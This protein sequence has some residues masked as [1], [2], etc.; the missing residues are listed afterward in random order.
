M[1]RFGVVVVGVFSAFLVAALALPAEA[2]DLQTRS[3]SVEATTTQ[4]NCL[5]G[6]QTKDG[7]VIG[8]DFE[9]AV[10]TEVLSDLDGEGTLLDLPV[11]TPT[12]LPATDPL[13]I[14]FDGKANGGNLAQTFIFTSVA[15]PLN[16]NN[17][18]VSE[19]CE[20]V[21]YPI[22]YQGQEMSGAVSDTLHSI[23]SHEIIHC[24]QH[25]VFSND[26]NE[27]SVPD[28]IIEGTAQYLG[29]LYADYPIPA[30]AD[31][32]RKGWLHD[33][34][35]DLVQRSYDAVG[36]YS[37]VADVNGDLWDKMVPA[38][39]AYETGGAAA[40]IAA[41][42]GDSQEVEMDW[43]PSLLN[44][45]DW[46]DAWTTP[47]LFVPADAQ[48][49]TLSG[50]VTESGESN[51]QS[52][53]P[54][55]AVID[56]ETEVP[57]GTLTISV[58]GGYA[59]VH[60]SGDDQDYLGFTDET[61]CV[62]SHACSTTSCPGSDASVTLPL[63]S[64]PYTLAVTGG[65]LGAKYTITNTPNAPPQ[66][67]ADDS[68]CFPTPP[69]PDNGPGGGGGGGDQG[70]SGGGGGGGG[71]NDSAFSEGD[72]HLQTLNDNSY[73]FQGAGEF[74][75]IRSNSGDMDI[76]AR[77]EPL[78]NHN[79]WAADTAVAM[80]VGKTRIEVDPGT[81]AHILINGHP[82]H[83]TKE[84]V[85]HL[86]DAGELTVTTANTVS[87]Q[88]PD[89]SVA[90]FDVDGRGINVTFTT[91]PAEAAHLK[92]LL[93]ALTHV[94]P[95]GNVKLEGGN[96]AHFTL[97]L[98]THAGFK[99]LYGAFANSWRITQ[100]AS[101]F[102]YARGK[103]TKTYT[104]AAF[105][106]WSV[107]HQSAPLSTREAAVRACLQSGITNGALLT[108]CEFDVATTG[109]TSYAR[110]TYQIQTGVAT[111]ERADIPFAANAIIPAHKVP[112]QA[113]TN[114]T[115]S[116]TLPES[117][118]TSAPANTTQSI[119]F[120]NN[121]PCALIT[122]DQIES[123]LGPPP[124]QSPESSPN[125]N[126]TGGCSYLSTSSQHQGLTYQFVNGPL[127]ANYK[128]NAIGGP[129]VSEP[130]L[131]TGAFCSKNTESGG[132]GVYFNV[133]T[134]NGTT[135]RMVLSVN[136]NKIQNGTNVETPSTNCAEETA[137]ASDALARLSG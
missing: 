55:A 29:N 32:W 47:G 131:G 58:T 44:N 103:N 45:P 52:V 63:L 119:A 33:T 94:T 121:N 64:A 12:S 84:T 127:T 11:I 83:V 43:G 27:A 28:F 23:L 76:Q 9:D 124:E 74:T 15:N 68:S 118:T 112:P 128:Q 62:G 65:G 18:L 73:D 93:T 7:A 122:A 1:H 137:L 20:I 105:P 22:A 24:Y 51:G 88:W 56:T 13:R 39:Q 81:Q 104:N 34:D 69:G 115:T 50:T 36:W 42:G 125:S 10:C 97:N 31:V 75:L 80:R 99:T 48:P 6:V 53:E 95:S 92:G 77:Q 113:N 2:S 90:Q 91:S 126:G 25:V 82:F 37:L 16:P 85:K 38:W 116:T 71:N 61:F 89:G 57:N 135:E 72:P 100:R 35:I 78:D 98:S 46:G 132:A 54:L 8:Q 108:D 79:P 136:N 30:T 67:E 4:S 102:T 134:Y 3:A 129:Y 40:F 14:I 109:Q 26:A 41:L 21:L 70:T 86:P 114:L 123:V 133:G 96:G 59:S 110:D 130:S 117:T 17:T 106:S 107:S 120:Y 101:L 60:G 49:E 66:L 19:P 5:D 111:E 87:V